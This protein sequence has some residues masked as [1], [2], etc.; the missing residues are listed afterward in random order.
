MID[1]NLGSPLAL[2]AGTYWLE[3]HEGTDVT[4]SDG[5]AIFWA[6]SNGSAGD[7][8]QDS[9]PTLPSSGQNVEL[10]FQ[11]FDTAS[12]P[13]PTTWVLLAAPLPAM[14]WFRRR[15]A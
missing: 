12:V 7:A 14:L 5:S 13:E 10:A 3:L 1:F 8:K 11:L 4:T 15:R 6:T 2:S 9:N